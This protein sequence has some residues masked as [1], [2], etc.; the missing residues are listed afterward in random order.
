MVKR[1]GRKRPIRSIISFTFGYY[2][3]EALSFLYRETVGGLLRFTRLGRLNIL[4]A[5]SSRFSDTWDGN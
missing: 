5:A 1:D 3:Q 2:D 4:N